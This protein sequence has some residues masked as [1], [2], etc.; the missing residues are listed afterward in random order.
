MPKLKHLPSEYAKG[1]RYFQ[2]IE[3]Y[4]GEKLT[5]S[6]SDIVGDEILMYGDYRHGES[7]SPH[8]VDMVLHWQR[9]ARGSQAQTLLGQRA[10][11]L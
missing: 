6:V 1:G 5:Q 4:E 9:M 2:S 3:A 10:Q 7:D 8:T 11:M